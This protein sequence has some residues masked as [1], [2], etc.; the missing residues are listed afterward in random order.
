MAGWWQGALWIIGARLH[1]SCSGRKALLGQQETL[2]Q[3]LAP[4]SAARVTAG[5]G[6]EEEKGDCFEFLVTTEPSRRNSGFCCSKLC[7]VIISHCPDSCFSFLRV[8]LIR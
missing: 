2:W 5:E 4:G 3:K 6:L 1:L 8:V 7:K